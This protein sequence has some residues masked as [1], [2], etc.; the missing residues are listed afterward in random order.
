MRMVQ[1]AQRAVDL[2]RA[3]TFYADLLGAAPSAS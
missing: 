1:V 2:G 3:A